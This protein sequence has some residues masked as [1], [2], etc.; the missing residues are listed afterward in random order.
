MQQFLFPKVKDLGP[1][2]FAD[3]VSRAPDEYCHYNFQGTHPEYAVVYHDRD[4]LLTDLY[5]SRIQPGKDSREIWDDRHYVVLKE[6]VNE[7]II[8]EL[9]SFEDIKGNTRITYFL[10]P[11]YRGEGLMGAAYEEFV[12]GL[13]REKPGLS[14]LFATVNADNKDSFR[15][16]LGRGFNYLGWGTD[17]TRDK[18]AGDKLSYY[19]SRYL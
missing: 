1:E 2:I 13:S 7:T 12:T 5:N 9:T 15:F 3:Y 8:G 11:Q 19:M 4:F 18:S 16:L 6:G 10:L 17:I 14:E